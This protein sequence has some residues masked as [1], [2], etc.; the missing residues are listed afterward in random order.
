[1]VAAFFF[2]LLACEKEE[3][4]PV[5]EACISVDSTQIQ[6]YNTLHFTNCSGKADY[7]VI[8]TGIEGSVYDML[9]EIPEKDRRGNYLYQTTKLSIKEG[10]TREYF[11]MA[12]GT[13]KAVLVATNVSRWGG[14]LKRDTASVT[15]T[16]Y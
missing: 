8:Y 3:V 9:E 11:Y 15:I 13:Y 16:V 14:E 2:S 12:P 10:E 4:I 7:Y 5:P 6:T 1:M